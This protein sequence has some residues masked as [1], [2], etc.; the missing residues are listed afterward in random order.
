MIAVGAATLVTASADGEIGR[1]AAVLVPGT[2]AMLDAFGTSPTVNA[3][4][5]V[6]AVVCGPRKY[7]RNNVRRRGAGPELDSGLT[8]APPSPGGC[9]L[10]KS[11][12]VIQ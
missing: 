12:S 2:V 5:L 4:V 9:S 1:E 8:E 7:G 3:I 10:D 11:E 6:V